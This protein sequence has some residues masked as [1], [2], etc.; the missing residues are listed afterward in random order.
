[1]LLYKFARLI[2]KY[3][4]SCQ[5]VTIT[6]GEWIAGEFTVGALDEKSING[7]I[8]PITEKRIQ[9]SGGTYKQGDCEFITTQ[10]IAITSKTYLV[11]K[12][13]KYKL[14]D[15]TDYSDYADF[16]VYVARR[17]SA[18]DTKSSTDTKNNVR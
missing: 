13:K 6:D 9:N 14:E 15:T 10:S 8:V 3:A 2:K 16:N 5:L 12:D 4:V 1:M 18:F 7:A 11:Y 17:V